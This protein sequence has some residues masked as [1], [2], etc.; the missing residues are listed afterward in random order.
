MKKKKINIEFQIFDSEEELEPSELD[1]IRAAQNASMSSYSPYSD[2][3]VGAALLSESGEIFTANNQ[4]NV[5]YPAGNCA[6]QNLVNYFKALHPDET[7]VCIAISAPKMKGNKPI[8]PCGICRQVLAE[9]E[10]RQ[11]KPIMSFL[12]KP[13]GQVWKLNSM[14]DYLPFAFEEWNLQED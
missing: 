12:H 13:D 8:T 9:V 6:E 14:R 7:I 3:P 5:S 11:S 10:H 2:F 1:L 4:E